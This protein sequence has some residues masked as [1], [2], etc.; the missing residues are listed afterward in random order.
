MRPGTA[1]PEKSRSRQ[2]V[3]SEL[4]TDLQLGD[5]IQATGKT[6]AVTSTTTSARFTQLQPVPVGVQTRSLD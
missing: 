6:G 3:S 2:L 1:A 5:H 4:Q